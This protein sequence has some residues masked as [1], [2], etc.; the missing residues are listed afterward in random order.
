MPTYQRFEF[1]ES[2]G[3]AAGTVAT[4]VAAAI[5]DTRKIS[6]NHERVNMV[7]T[8]ARVGQYY[9]GQPI[10]A[11][12]W[13]E[14]D[15]ETF[16]R[17]QHTQDV[18]TPEGALF[19]AAGWQETASGTTPAIV[20]KYTL[21]N[22]HLAATTLPGASDPCLDPID[23]TVNHDSLQY[24]LDGCVGTGVINFTAGQLPYVAWKFRGNCASEATSSTTGYTE[25]AS[26][27][28][29]TQGD[30]AVPVQNEGPTLLVNTTTTTLTGVKSIELD[31]GNIFNDRDI[32]GGTFGFGQRIITG[33]K[34]TLTMVVESDLLATLNP[35]T[36]IVAGNK[37]T[38]GWTHNS[39]GGTGNVITGSFIGA[40]SN[41]EP[42]YINGQLHYTCTL[43]QYKGAAMPYLAWS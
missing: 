23:F 1:N 42:N 21:G 13:S 15:F 40:L 6:V 14:L 25:T 31:S 11:G 29:Y 34:P 17:G 2:V 16:L 22:P 41:V 9:P 37:W 7:D 36:D 10:P 39:G 28:S 5:Y 8:D 35:H 4:P 18:P 43:A 32:M 26:A 30:M 38:I 24:I 19:R 27:L 3:W 12:R 33:F 20:Y